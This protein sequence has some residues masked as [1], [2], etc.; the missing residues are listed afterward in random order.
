MVLEAS[1]LI[2]KDIHAAWQVLGRDFANAHKWASAVNHSEGFGTSFN[3]ATCSER[4]CSTTMGGIKEKLIS[5]SEEQHMLSYVVSEGM[6]SI[7]QYASNTWQL[8][9]TGKNNTRLQITIDIRPKNI[10][11]KLM[12]PLLKMKFTS[13]GNDLLHDFKSYVETGKPSA[14]K[15]K[16]ISKK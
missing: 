6:P 12:T 15:L 8:T 10:I 16:A 11:G 4:G 13:I 7:I 9:E 5:F 14:K 2:N 3:G 1:I